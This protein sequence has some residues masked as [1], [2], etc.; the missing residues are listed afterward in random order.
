LP[1]AE[2][3]RKALKDYIS[4][5]S[6]ELTQYLYVSQERLAELEKKEPE[7]ANLLKI[8]LKNMRDG[9]T[10]ENSQEREEAR[11]NAMTSYDNFDE[12]DRMAE[13][14]EDVF[15]KYNVK[16][17]K[18]N[19]T[20]KLHAEV[21]QA[22]HEAAAEGKVAP[23]AEEEN[24]PYK[25]KEVP[26]E[27]VV[28]HI[29]YE[30]PDKKLTSSDIQA[31]YN[32]R[33]GYKMS[34][35][36]ATDRLRKL[37]KKGSPHFKGSKETVLQGGAA[38]KW[39]ITYSDDGSA[40]PL[41]PEEGE[42]KAEKKWKNKS[43]NTR[44]FS[45]K[46]GMEL[47]I[48]ACEKNPDAEFD[49]ESFLKY[50]KETGVKLTGTNDPRHSVSYFISNKLVHQGAQK[51]EFK[52]EIAATG[53]HKVVFKLKGEKCIRTGKYEISGEFLDVAGQYIEDGL[54]IEDWEVLAS[55]R[56]SAPITTLQL[57]EAKS[58]VITYLKSRKKHAELD[59]KGRIVKSD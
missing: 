34:S 23:D 49:A 12:L 41:A 3:I 33:L 42:V 35:S 59:E 4:K 30:K 40:K 8:T 15:K 56:A 29:F 25:K 6:E 5:R 14:V 46:Y 17:K 10:F 20:E 32:E 48:E 52:K 1:K 11:E 47:A 39:V 50:L 28:L 27:D 57:E 18:L 26:V 53:G 45:M 16:P 7:V 54:V 43:I 55:M 2:E 21:T 13:A 22:A 37:M 19:Y 44:D 58:E 24:I 31:F 9:I 51:L 36:A 38:K